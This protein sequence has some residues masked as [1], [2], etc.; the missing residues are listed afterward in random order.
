MRLVPWA[1]KAPFLYLHGI[2]STVPPTPPMMNSS[3]ILISILQLIVPAIL[4]LGC[5][6]WWRHTKHWPFMVFA[7]CGVLYFALGASTFVIT[8]ISDFGKTPEEVVQD[9]RMH[10]NE[11]FQTRYYFHAGIL[12]ASAIAGLGLIQIPKQ[13]PPYQKTSKNNTD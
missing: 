9:Q 2:S 1:T 6:R 11:Q 13:T 10:L 8:N 5:F 3:I 7:V 12:L 4:A